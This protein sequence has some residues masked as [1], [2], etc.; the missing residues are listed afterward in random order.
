[1]VKSS[2]MIRCDF[3]VHDNWVDLNHAVP[4]FAV[5]DNHGFRSNA[6]L[7]LLNVCLI[8]LKRSSSTFVKVNALPIQIPKLGSMI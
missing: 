1:M 5:L 8:L 4:C 3:G 6:C 7:Q 2:Y